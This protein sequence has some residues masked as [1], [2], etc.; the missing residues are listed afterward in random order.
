MTEE[1]RN[2]L[3]QLAV[4]AIAEMR[5]GQGPRPP[6]TRDLTSLDLLQDHEDKSVNN[7]TRL[8]P[9]EQCIPDLSAPGAGFEDDFSRVVKRRRRAP[10]SCLLCRKRKVRCD[11]QMPCSAC[12]TANVTGSCEYAPPTW[13]GRE[14]RGGQEI[15]FTVE[16]T[17]PPQ[18]ANDTRG[19]HSS[20]SSCSNISVPM[21]KPLTPPQMLQP[22]VSPLQPTVKSKSSHQR[23]YGRFPN[24]ANLLRADVSERQRTKGGGEVPPSPKKKKQPL[25]NDA[26]CKKAIETLQETRRRRSADSPIDPVYKPL[27]DLFPGQQYC[28]FLIDSFLK[29]VNSVHYCACPEGLRTDFNALWSAKQR[30]EDGEQFNARTYLNLPSIAV[31]LLVFRLGRGSY[32]LKDWSPPNYCIKDGHKDNTY[33]GPQVLEV[34]EACL[35]ASHIF[36]HGGLKTIQALVLMKLDCLYA[37][38]SEYSPDGVDSVNLTG[39]ILQL[40]LS[41]GLYMDPANFDSQ[42]TS[43]LAFQD[44]LLVQSPKAHQRSMSVSSSGSASLIEPSSAKLW[45]ILYGCALILDAKRNL[46]V[47]IPL[48]LPQ[49]DCDVYFDHTDDGGKTASNVLAFR[50]AMLRFCALSGCVMTETSRPVMYRN[51]PLILRLGQDLHKFGVDEVASLAQLR[52][53]LGIPKDDS[54]AFSSEEEHADESDTSSVAS[55]ASSALQLIHRCRIY[56]LWSK[57]CVHYEMDT[58][59]ASEEPLYGHRELCARLGIEQDQAGVLSQ[60]RV[61]LRMSSLI[62]L[63]VWVARRRTASVELGAHSWYIVSLVHS[64][65]G[66][67][68]TGVITCWFRVAILAKETGSLKGTRWDPDWLFRLITQGIAVLGDTDVGDKQMHAL[69]VAFLKK[70]R[71]DLERLLAKMNGV[72][73]EY[74]LAQFEAVDKLAEV[75]VLSEEDEGL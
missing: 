74:L 13:G 71:A 72:D 24:A 1:S 11:K 70:A 21:Q 64:M 67:P 2:G 46:E 45:R 30:I 9:Y 33:L 65:M 37:P 59:D 27:L 58:Y 8:A 26:K 20:S 55:S 53:E 35:N 3:E 47:G 40:A 14:V 29:R 6:D 41:Q 10:V 51:E 32:P 19:H 7:S 39:V 68:L 36:R 61:I 69:C 25:H 54:L 34:A 18:S 60:Y 44:S 56:C 4:R 31:M 48:S 5:E 22:I 75:E 63:L 15:Q 23:M 17:D 50:R 62:T 73:P 28:E 52:E 49:G 16:D 38:D 66:L 12:K 57:L 42:S 43:V